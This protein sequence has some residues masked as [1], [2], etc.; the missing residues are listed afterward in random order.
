M[1]PDISDLIMK[2]RNSGLPGD[3]CSELE[4]RL[5]REGPQMD[6]DR[7]IEEALLQGA[8]KPAISTAAVPGTGEETPPR[9]IYVERTPEK[10]QSAGEFLAG[11]VAFLVI[12]AFVYYWLFPALFH[13]PQVQAK[14]REAFYVSAEEMYREYERNEIAAEQ[15]YKNSAVMVRG[16][17]ESIGRDILDTAYVVLS[18]GDSFLLGVQCYFDDSEAYSLASLS[19]GQRVTISGVVTG[20][21]GNITVEGCRIR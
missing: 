6:V 20:K 2:I 11:L 4:K 1:V 8:P 3:V 18:G 14:N 13:K 12:C 21:L 9:V 7:A 5:I 17:V 15:K 10:K 16:I 19:P